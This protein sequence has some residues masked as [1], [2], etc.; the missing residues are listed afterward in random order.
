M[1]YKDHHLVCGGLVAGVTLVLI[2]ATQELEFSTFLLQ[3]NVPY[4]LDL[5]LLSQYCLKEASWTFFLLNAQR[6]PCLH[7]RSAQHCAI[8]WGDCLRQ[9]VPKRFYLQF[10]KVE[11]T[12]RDH[13]KTKL[14]F[15]KGWLYHFIHVFFNGLEGLSTDFWKLCFERWFSFGYINP[16][17]KEKKR[18]IC[19][20]QQNDSS[21]DCKVQ[22]AYH[23]FPWPLNV[24]A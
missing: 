13:K 24:V 14:K 9:A 22:F 8:S 2:T 4:L 15:E 10:E 17:L 6:C 18:C 23:K 16:D 19:K 12:K 1:C 21:W 7:L 3:H 11:L 20:K 5:T